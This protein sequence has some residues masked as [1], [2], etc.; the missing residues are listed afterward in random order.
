MSGQS[1]SARLLCNTRSWRKTRRGENYFTSLI[2]LLHTLVPPHPVL[3]RADGCGVLGTGIPSMPPSPG[4]G[5]FARGGPRKL[6]VQPSGMRRR[7]RQFG[8]KGENL[9]YPPKKSV[10][11][12]GEERSG[13][14]LR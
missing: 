10:G 4:W 6:R 5:P 11:E 9:G 14:E 3:L 7:L 1:G 8:G 2:V 13:A 12:K